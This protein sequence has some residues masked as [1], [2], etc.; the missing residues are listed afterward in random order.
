[1]AGDWIKIETSLPDKPEVDELATL[2]GIDHDTVV[3]KLIRI[4]AWADKHT[5][6]GNAIS[7][8]SPF[9]DRITFHPGFAVALRKVGWLSGREGSLDLPHFDRHNGQTAKGR[10][11]TNQ[12]VAEHRKKGACNAPVTEIPLQ[13]SLPEKRR[14]DKDSEKRAREERASVPQVGSETNE[15]WIGRMKH[16]YPD[17]DV[18][19]ELRRLGDLAAKDGTAL[20]RNRA[21]AWLRKASPAVHP[22]GKKSPKYDTIK[23]EDPPGWLAWVRS[24]FGEECQAFKQRL[25]FADASKD[26]Q[27]QF[28]KSNP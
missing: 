5:I 18:D 23:P 7:V 28:R 15:E 4:W 11:T 10:A 6:S 20:S 26:I 3:G 1:M 22:P 17:R 21:E 8:T 12:R 19:G 25:K 14:E 13:K 27:T 9:I 24:E 2:L 16:I